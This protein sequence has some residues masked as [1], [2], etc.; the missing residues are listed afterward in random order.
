MTKK[1]KIKIS[2]ASGYLGIGISEELK[3]QGHE[4]SGIQRKLIYGSLEI[5]SKEIEGSDVIINL[6]GAPILQ[7]WTNRKKRLIHES[8]V[9]TTRNLIKAIN[10]LP[11][12]KQPKKF[13]SASAIGIYKPGFLH[14][15]N[16]T[17]F[18]DGFVGT[19][20]KDWEDACVELWTNVQKIIMRIGLVLG[21]NAKIISYSKIPF[22]L[23][24]G[25]RLGNGKQPFPF[26]HEQDVTGA[27]VWA[28]NDFENNGVF[29]LVAPENITNKDFTKVL[30]KTYNRPA[31]FSIPSFVVKIVLGEAAVLL[32]ESPEVVPKNLLEAGFQFKYPALKLALEEIV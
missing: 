17:N 14:D 4:V 3:K 16:S 10:D 2:G 32:L 18:D 24:L 13:I 28:V 1:M 26:I 31:I 29:N 7:R 15:E 19:I 5:L 25:A 22:K 20:A 23:G 27:F 9:R 12:E 30:A 21:K 6:A 11:K 8:R